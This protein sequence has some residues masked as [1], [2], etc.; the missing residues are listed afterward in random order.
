MM[1]SQVVQAAAEDGQ[2][3]HVAARAGEQEA[4]RGDGGGQHGQVGVE[5][6]DFREGHQLPGPRPAQDVVPVRELRAVQL[7]QARFIVQA[8]ELEPGTLQIIDRHY[9]T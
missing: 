5:A 1:R 7:V 6:D 2:D 3:V 9:R 4:E 8:D